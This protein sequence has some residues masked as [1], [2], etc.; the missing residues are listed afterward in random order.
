MENKKNMMKDLNVVKQFLLSKGWKILKS[1]ENSAEEFYA[2]G[3]MYINFCKDGIGIH[4]E[5]GSKDCVFDEE[6]E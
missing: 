4:L 5:Y 1:P 2:Q 6:E 3:V